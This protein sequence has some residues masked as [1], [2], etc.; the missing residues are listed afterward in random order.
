MDI[1]IS[2]LDMIT[3]VVFALKL[4]ELY[5]NSFQ[6]QTITRSG[7]L[8]GVLHELGDIIHAGVGVGLPPRLG[9]ELNIRHS[10]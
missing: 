6:G 8:E 7:Y 9:V 1:E 2:F 3:I 4:N 5:S 10:V